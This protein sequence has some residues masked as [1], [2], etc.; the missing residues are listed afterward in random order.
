MQKRRFLA[1]GVFSRERAGIQ[2]AWDEFIPVEPDRYPSV[3]EPY[4]QTSA[5]I[6][7]AAMRDDADWIAFGHG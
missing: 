3:R 6:V 2:P 4:L 7:Y 5:V 1:N